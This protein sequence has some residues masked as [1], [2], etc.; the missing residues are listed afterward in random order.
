MTSLVLEKISRMREGGQKLVKILADLEKL[1]KPGVNLLKIEHQ[2]WQLIEKQGGYPSFA[3]VPGYTFATCLN[4][5][6]GVVHG[7]PSDYN[8]KEGD[9]LNIDIGFFYKGYHTDYAKSL[10]VTEGK[11]KNYPHLKK[12]LRTG[13]KTLNEAIKMAK[14]GNYVGHVSAKIQEIIEK[15]GYR[16]VKQY[17][18]HGIGKN[19]HEPPTIPCVLNTTLEKT[20]ILSYNMTI[21]I[22]VIYTMEKTEVKVS[23][24]GWSVKTVNGSLAA[25]FEKTVL[26]SKEEPLVIT[27]W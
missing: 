27:P 14:A 22:E 21:A 11:E 2:A 15:T 19:L 7:I 5:N 18:G 25:C 23:P 3:K 6:D 9:L 12:F 16:T 10:I 8:L 20:Q 17:S 26:V 1:A 4:V 13:E 24:D